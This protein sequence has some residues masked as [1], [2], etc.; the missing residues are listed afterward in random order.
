MPGVVLSIRD[1]DGNELPRGE[2]GEVWA[3][4]GNFMREYWNKPEATAEVFADGW[5][6]TGDAGYLDEGNYL[7]LVD[8]VKDM[9]VTGG[10][11]VYSTEV[12]S[13]ISKH[14]AVE[15]VAVI[16]IPHDVWGEQVHAIVVL[17]QGAEATEDEIREFARRAHR[18]LQGP[19]VG[20]VPRRAPAAV[21]CHEGPQARAARDVLGGPRARR[22]LTAG[23]AQGYVVPA[24]RRGRGRRSAYL[25]A[26]GPSDG[27]E[28]HVGGGQ[29]AE[30]VGVGQPGAQRGD[31]DGELAT[32]DAARC[33][34][35]PDRAGPTPARA[36][37]T[38]PETQLGA[39]TDHG[40]REPRRRSAATS[41]DGSIWKE[42]NRKKVAA[43]R[44]RNGAISSTARSRTGPDRARPT[45]K[46]PM[47]LDTWSCSARPPTSRVSPNTASSRASF[48]PGART[49][50]SRSP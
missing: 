39:A 3:K 25:A 10:E 7:F 28:E 20:R 6:H 18:R 2:T 32:G 43:N 36:A 23:A 35:A 34:P 31:H 1:E 8:R 33:R 5:Y 4:A 17:H 42:K 48:A 26:S 47:A 9:I 46:A 13:A 44:S 40:Q 29:R 38:H 14:E 22:Q 15:Q 50:L 37:A 19:Q 27:G 45:R 30:V 21:G 24:R 41:D 11:N 49:V 12:E 16:G